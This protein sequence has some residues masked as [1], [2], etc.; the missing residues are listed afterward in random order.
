MSAAADNEKRPDNLP[1][2]Q[3]KNA[4]KQLFWYP[5][6]AIVA[7]VD[8]TS[9]ASVVKIF[10]SFFQVVWDL[11]NRREKFTKSVNLDP[12]QLIT[13]DKSQVLLERTEL[14]LEANKKYALFGENAV[15]KTMLFHD[16]A[17]GLVKDFPKYLHVHHCEEIEESPDA[18]SV[19]ETVVQSH[20]V[21]NA[22]TVAWEKINAL[23]DG[24]KLGAGNESAAA[25][26][27]TKEQLD[28]WKFTKDW[29][30]NRMR[31]VGYEKSYAEAEKM[32]RVLGFDDVGLQQSTNSLS[33]GLRMRVALC[34]SFFME[35]DL[36]L[37][38]DPTNHLDFPSVLW[39][40]NRLKGYRGTF[41][42][43][44]HD[45]E[46]LQ[47]TCQAVILFE[48]KRLKYYMKNWEQFEK[49]KLL[50][51]KKK[52]EAIDKFLLANRNIDFSSP[53]AREKADKQAW[54]KKISR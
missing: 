19:L 25:A 46:M 32:L 47:A 37:L 5:D 12:F 34:A 49:E 39:L 28:G 18:K 1:P 24:V 52:N 48:D 23:I 31:I 4:A 50:E 44:T 6:P 2:R 20:A 35:A 9:I 29:I 17:T 14:I 10:P 45:R 22:L 11:E 54:Q 16:I 42:M 26:P 40:E 36:L 8:W 3:F 15:G 27:P 43:V 30:E 38:D 41:V 53:L 7:K 51:D 21:R 33:G 13:P